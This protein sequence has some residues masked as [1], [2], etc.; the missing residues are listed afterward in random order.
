MASVTVALT[1]V[2]FGN[3]TSSRWSDNVD[4]LGLHLAAWMA[5]QHSPSMAVRLVWHGT[6]QSGMS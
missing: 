4:R 1:G 2:T 3:S 5:E 6:C